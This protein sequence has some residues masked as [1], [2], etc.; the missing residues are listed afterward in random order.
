MRS[1]KIPSGRL[2]VKAKEAEPKSRTCFPTQS[3]RSVAVG[4]CHV[5]EIKEAQRGFLPPRL[6]S[7][8]DVGNE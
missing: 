7:L 2:K 1:Q 3:C 8:S 6:S 4:V 5:L